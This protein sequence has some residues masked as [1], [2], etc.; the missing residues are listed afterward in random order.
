MAEFCK[1]CGLCC[2]HMRTP[3]F[4]GPTDPQWNELA[5]E[6]KRE[7][8]SWVIGPSPRYELMVKFDG[9]VNPCIWLDLVSGK[10]K[11][12]ELRPDVCRDYEVGNQSCRTIRREVGLTV[13]GMPV[14][15][16]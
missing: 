3:P 10:C 9:K 15:I 5:D 8:E 7:I 4:L 14:V 2:M 1:N 12:Y 16:E 6:L 13:K 11:H